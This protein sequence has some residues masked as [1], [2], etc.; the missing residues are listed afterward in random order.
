MWVPLGDTQGVIGMEAGWR[1]EASSWAIE[2][3]GHPPQVL[4][5]QDPGTTLVA[6][7]TGHIHP[8]PQL[9]HLSPFDPF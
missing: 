2:A 3:K 7:D 4:R 9:P 6:K 8:G 1:A 5:S